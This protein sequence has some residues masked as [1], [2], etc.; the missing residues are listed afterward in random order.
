MSLEASQQSNTPICLVILMGL[1]A[2]GKSSLSQK[3]VQAYA[4][5]GKTETLAVSISYDDF[6][7]HDIQAK[8]AALSINQQTK[9]SESSQSLTKTLKKKFVHCVTHLINLTRKEENEK[10]QLDSTEEEED[11]LPNSHFEEKIKEVSE[12]ILENSPS[13]LILLI[14]DNHYYSSMRSDYYNLAKI[15][16]L[17]FCILYCKTSVKTCRAR[18]TLRE[19]PFRVLDKTIIEMS[20]KLE[21]PNPM[22]NPEDAFCLQIGEDSADNQ[23]ISLILQVLDNSLINPVEW[24]PAPDR[25]EEIERERRICSQNE[26]HQADQILRK[27]VNRELGMASFLKDKTN[28]KKLMS[29]EL[30]GKR[31]TVLEQLRN[32]QFKIRAMVDQD[33]EFRNEVIQLV[34]SV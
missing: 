32:G 25:S 6:V 7:S 15:H 10:L 9:P 8:C 5:Q 26:I 27:W 3:I 19:E 28:N 30:N 31:A 11:L 29:K 16:R 20:L 24:S 21:E 4:Q 1:P 22:E 18:N 2:S 13:N 23:N 14:D 34:M 17:G 33:I 12:Q